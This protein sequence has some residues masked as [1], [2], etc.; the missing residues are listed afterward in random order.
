VIKLVWVVNIKGIGRLHWE[1]FREAWH[2]YKSF[3]HFD[4][5]YKMLI[6]PKIMSAIDFNQMKEF[7]GP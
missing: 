5:G 1:T 3:R 6:Y 2:D 7:E 4:D